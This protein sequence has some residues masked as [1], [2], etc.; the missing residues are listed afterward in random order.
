MSS[1]VAILVKIT[2]GHGFGLM[3]NFLSRN[4]LIGNVYT[5]WEQNP[6]Y[7]CYPRTLVSAQPTPKFGRKWPVLGLL[8]PK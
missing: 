2:Y 8:G 6:M 5:A 7:R 3:Q 1:C 4:Q